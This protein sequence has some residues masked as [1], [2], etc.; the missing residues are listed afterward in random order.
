VLIID[1]FEEII[2][3][4]AGRWE[5]RSEFFRQLDAALQLPARIFNLGDHATNEFTP[6]PILQR[7]LLPRWQR[8]M[9]FSA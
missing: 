1:Q 5:E 7:Y 2:T 3:A 8:I 4:H 6:P 9:F